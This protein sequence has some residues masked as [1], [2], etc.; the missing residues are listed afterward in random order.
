MSN[1]RFFT[2]TLNFKI[3]LKLEEIRTKQK[4]FNFQIKESTF[5]NVY[6]NEGTLKNLKRPQ[7]LMNIKIISKNKL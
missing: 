5:L 4:I 6:I 3:I 1:L 2:K 7:N